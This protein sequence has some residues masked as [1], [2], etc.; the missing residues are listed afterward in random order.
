[1]SEAKKL[2]AEG[3]YAEA[4][5]SVRA[6]MTR[7]PFPDG[8]DFLGYL[9]E[10]Q[11]KLDQAEEAYGQAVKLNSARHSSKVR[12]GIVYGKKGKYADCIVVLENLSSDIR[13]NPEALFYLSRSY[14]ETRNTAKALEIA[15]MVERLGENDPGALLSVGR[16]LLSKDLNQQAVPMLKKVVN[17]LPNS[18]E[19]HY[20][21]ALALFKM[22]KYDEM[23]IYLDQAQN[24]DP[25]ATRILLLRALSLLDDGKFSAAKDY[26]RKARA[27][28][29][30][31][32]L[33]AYL[34]G[35]V[36]IEEKN[37]SEAI[38]LISD[39]IASGFND[40]KAHLSLISAYR[41]NGEFE[42]AV[43]YALKLVQTF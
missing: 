31:D 1:L 5:A 22:R 42:K 17:H 11:S 37:Y 18:S 40:F 38:K 43:N 32:K 10:Q 26:I 19:A 25:A 21:L 2:V 27:L 3:K 39:L 28:S 12:L 4:E 30:E 9:Y 29:P 36:L 35:R 24:L 6:L 15:A 34:W 33:A 7:Q 14:L 16:L 23:S 20:C 13:D 41:N 8:F